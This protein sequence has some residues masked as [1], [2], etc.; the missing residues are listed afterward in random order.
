MADPNGQVVTDI[1]STIASWKMVLDIT[2]GM[3]YGC[4][5]ELNGTERD[6]KFIAEVLLCSQYL[7]REP[8]NPIE[9]QF[10][11]VKVHV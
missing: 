8:I 7:G 3:R 9:L 4:I 2:E 5:F 6:R 1:L 11:A 10:Q